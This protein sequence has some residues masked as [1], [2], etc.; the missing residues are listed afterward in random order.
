MQSRYAD[1][2]AFTLLL[3]SFALAALL[4]HFE[5]LP[6]FVSFL[7]LRVPLSL[8][9][10]LLLPFSSFFTCFFPFLFILFIP[11]FLLFSYSWFCLGPS[12]ELCPLRLTSFGYLSCWVP[13]VPV[14]LADRATLAVR[15]LVNGLCV[16]TFCLPPSRTNS[17][18]SISH[19][20]SFL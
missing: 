17:V 5:F 1:D 16:V 8:L 6:P 9:S 14:R 19:F 10:F 20:K 2:A 7:T 15:S 18:R 11:L 3:S 13:H 12:C 4:G